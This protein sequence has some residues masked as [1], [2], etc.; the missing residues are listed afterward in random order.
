MRSLRVL[1]LTDRVAPFSLQTE[2]S[3]MSAELHGCAH[4]RSW[5]IPTLGC[6]A[7]P[8]AYAAFAPLAKVAMVATVVVAA[9]D[10]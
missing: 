10:P 8:S 2:R 7:V 3:F 1:R 4:P 6:G 9:R 5:S